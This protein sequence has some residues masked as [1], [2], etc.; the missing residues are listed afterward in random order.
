[1]P[2]G[3]EQN[4]Y[5]YD[6]LHQDTYSCL[7]VNQSDESFTKTDSKESQIRYLNFRYVT[8]LFSISLSFVLSLSHT[9]SHTTHTRTHTAFPSV[10]SEVI[11]VSLRHIEA[12]HTN[13]LN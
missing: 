13:I 12:E 1:M 10:I 7:D 4:P 9:R 11:R 2:A 6:S 5:Q 3:D 8:Q